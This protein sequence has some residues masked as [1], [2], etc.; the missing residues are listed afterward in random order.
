VKILFGTAVTVA[1]LGA[2]PAHAQDD[3][4]GAG[5]DVNFQVFSDTLAPYGQWYQDPQYGTVWMP[6]SVDG[7][8]RPYSHGRWA[9]TAY[10]WTWVGEEPWAWAAFHYGRWARLDSGWA[11][12]PDY[13]WGPAWVSFRFGDAYVGWMPLPPGIGYGDN[14]YDDGDPVYGNW[15]FVG[16]DAFYPGPGSYSLY[17]ALIAPAV[18]RGT[19]WVST[20]PAVV[21]AN[22]GVRVYGPPLEVV[23]QHTGRA[24]VPATIHSVNHTAARTSRFE[25]GAV[26]LAVPEFRGKAHPF[27][28]VGQSVEGTH[29][30][31]IAPLVGNRTTPRP[32]VHRFSAPVANP[33]KV[34]GRPGSAPPK[35]NSGGT[36]SRDKE[37]HGQAPSRSYGRA[38]A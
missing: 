9:W 35:S 10:G 33:R 12:V 23:T 26:H 15:C 36:Q 31:G 19:V 25:D 37:P 27:G 3:D 13:T 17:G 5:Q 7:D 2:L 32:D 34:P 20:R 30:V 28:G 14:G 24:V 38:R 22:N 1:F 4:Q 11:W 18:V 16:Y 21:H 6:N 8:W 29:P